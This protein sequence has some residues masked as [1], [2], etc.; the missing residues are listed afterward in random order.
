MAGEGPGPIGNP[1]YNDV[2]CGNGPVGSPDENRCPGRIDHG[3]EGCAMIG[4]KCQRFYAIPRPS[5][6]LHA[7]GIEEQL[8]DTSLPVPTA[9]ASSTKEQTSVCSCHGAGAK[10]SYRK[11]SHTQLTS[12]AQL[13]QEHLQSTY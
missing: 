12:P 8:P 11:L 5:P 1:I 4:P 13:K 2:Q 3:E 7:A 9:E 6:V 10:K